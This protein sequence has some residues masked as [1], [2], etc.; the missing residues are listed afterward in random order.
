M[1][2]ILRSHTDLIAGLAG[3]AGLADQDDD[4]LG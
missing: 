3:L 2:G 1:R 4:G